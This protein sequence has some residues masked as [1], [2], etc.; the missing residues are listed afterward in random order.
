M[1]LVLFMWVSVL[2][3]VILLMLFLGVMMLVRVIVLLL[4]LV[5]WFV[6]CML[7]CELV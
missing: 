7:M 3:D 6:L 1:L 2:I 4:V 5:N